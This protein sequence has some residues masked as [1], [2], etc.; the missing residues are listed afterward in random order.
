MQFYTHFKAFLEILWQMLFGAL[1]IF[2]AGTVF[3][4]AIQ[5]LDWYLIN[6]VDPEV[7]HGR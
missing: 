3:L 6:H 2:V 7:L 1:L 5:I 4:E